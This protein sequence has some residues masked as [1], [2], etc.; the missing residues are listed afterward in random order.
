VADNALQL[1]SSMT[2]KRYVRTVRGVRH[3]YMTTPH[4]CPRSGHWDTRVKLW[5]RDGTVDTLVTSQRCRR[6]RGVRAMS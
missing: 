5:W 2:M 1:G 3:G 4:R 6:R